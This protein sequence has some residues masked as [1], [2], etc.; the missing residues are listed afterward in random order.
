MFLL[1]S[2]SIHCV[3]DSSVINVA[4][5]FNPDII[6]VRIAAS[7]GER[8]WKA[9]INYQAEHLGIRLFHLNDPFNSEIKVEI[10]SL[11]SHAGTSLLPFSTPK[12]E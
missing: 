8:C 11:D 9:M 7:R 10:E 1:L 3:I 5:E 12:M 4:R 6:P 2:A